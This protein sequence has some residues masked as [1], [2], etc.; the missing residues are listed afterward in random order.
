MQGSRML[1]PRACGRV[2]GG[3]AARARPVQTQVCRSP[4]P[5][6][7]WQGQLFLDTPSG[8]ARRPTHRPA[9][10]GPDASH[11]RSRPAAGLGPQVSLRSPAR[12]PPPRHASDP[13]RL[14][15]QGCR[16]GDRYGLGY[17]R[18]Q[19]RC[20]CRGDTGCWVLLPRHACPTG[21]RLGRNHT[22]FPCHVP[23]GH[24]T[25]TAVLIC[26][27]AAISHQPMLVQH[28]LDSTMR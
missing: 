24:G 16:I 17:F 5:L 2:W 6:P 21:N 11:A 18:V 27:T 25:C 8:T 14:Q 3:R 20:T 1:Q 10:P 15:V 4:L 26:D 13:A 19:G 28:Y 12:A 9:R 7:G 23:G 22:S